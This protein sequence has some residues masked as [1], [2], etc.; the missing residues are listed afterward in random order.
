MSKILK[1]TSRPYYPICEFDQCEFDQCEF[2]QCEF[3][4]CEFNQCEIND[5]KKGCEFF[6]FINLDLLNTDKECYTIKII[7]DNKIIGYLSRKKKEYHESI[8][9]KVG[10][11]NDILDYKYY[12]DDIYYFVVYIN[13]KDTIYF[14]L[15]KYGYF[16]INPI[17]TFNNLFNTF[18]EL[19]NVKN[20][21]P[22]IPDV[23]SYDLHDMIITLN[24]EK[25]DDNLT[26]D[27]VMEN[28]SYF[29]NN[30]VLK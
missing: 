25:Y 17:Y 9:I 16:N 19:F 12:C 6:P 7:I 5:N 30:V 24:Y 10:S 11:G 26:I 13:L 14:E 18:K 29:Y 4:Q 15:M 21:K 2:N 23:Q 28:I 1:A 22:I 27:D 8:K 20:G 3:N